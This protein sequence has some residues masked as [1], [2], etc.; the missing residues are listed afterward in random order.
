[1]MPGEWL[2][3]HKMLQVQIG[4]VVIRKQTV[5]FSVASCIGLCPTLYMFVRQ[6]TF[7][8]LIL[9]LKIIKLLLKFALKAFSKRHLRIGLNNLDYLAV[10]KIL[11]LNAKF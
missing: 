3:G 7:Y 6:H 10:P 5:T 4:S 9:W 1:M 2:I 11:W 8:F